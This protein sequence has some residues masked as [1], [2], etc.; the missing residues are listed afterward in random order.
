[1]QEQ[2][3]PVMFSAWMR[4]AEDFKDWITGFEVLTEYRGGG[5]DSS[6]G[7]YTVPEDG[8]YI[9]GLKAVSGSQ[10]GWSQINFYR[11]NAVVQAVVTD[12]N[13]EDNYNNL[14]STWTATLKKGDK[15][16]LKVT[17][18]TVRAWL[19]WWGVRIFAN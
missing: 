9:F 8:I 2:T 4:R 18:G 16:R 13:K 6:S 7:T 19:H 3:K 1:M 5:F 14:G 11:N 15:L 17:S 12:G 10:F